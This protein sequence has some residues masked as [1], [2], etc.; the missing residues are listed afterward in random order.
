MSPTNDAGVLYVVSG[1]VIKGQTFKDL[2]IVRVFFLASRFI[3]ELV[4]GSLHIEWGGFTE[5]Y[6]RQLFVD[7]VRKVC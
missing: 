1:K 3:R 6:I 5:S 7:A 2:Q 4:G